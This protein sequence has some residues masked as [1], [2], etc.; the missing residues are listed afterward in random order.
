MSFATGDVADKLKLTQATGALLNNR[1]NR[2]TPLTA[3]QNALSF[4]SNFVNFTYAN[5]VFNEDMLKEFALWVTQ[6]Q[7]RF[8]LYTWGLD[9][10]ALGQSGSS[11][12]EWA[13]KNT[14]GVVPC[15]WH[16]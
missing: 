12:G 7:N 9:P 11:F 6:Q 3:A 5:G 4:S 16:V 15:L 8:K 1:T 14:S 13:M 10:V 2:D